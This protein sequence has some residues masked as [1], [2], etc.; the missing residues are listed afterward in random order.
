M[1]YIP[2]SPE[3]RDEMLKIV[4]LSS[5]DELFRSIPSGIQLNRRLNITEPLAE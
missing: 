1:R 5:A 2:N 3:E 4:G